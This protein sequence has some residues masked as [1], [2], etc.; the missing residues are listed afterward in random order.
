M[1]VFSESSS[2]AD[3]STALLLPFPVMVAFDF[4]LPP[5]IKASD[6]LR[7]VGGLL[8]CNGLVARGGIDMLALSIPPF[9]RLTSADRPFLLA[10]AD[11]RLDGRR[12]REVVRDLRRGGS[13]SLPLLDGGDGEEE[14][15]VFA[16]SF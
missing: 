2:T 11:T 12:E 4:G 6:V 10:F 3:P 7:E 9:I 16:D 15:D 13:S 5:L 8:S 1:G 14:L